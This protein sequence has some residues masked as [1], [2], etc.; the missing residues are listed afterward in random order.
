MQQP[1]TLEDA[2]RAFIDAYHGEVIFDSLRDYDDSTP[3]ANSM[4]GAEAL[5]KLTTDDPKPW[6]VEPPRGLA[7]KGPTRFA[8]YS[9]SYPNAQAE[10][11]V[12]WDPRPREARFDA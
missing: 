10:G 8:T 7:I 4:K 3:R 6:R 2:A 11:R 12:L 5:L 9:E 1:I